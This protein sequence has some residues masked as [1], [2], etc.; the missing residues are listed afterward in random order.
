MPGTGCDVMVPPPFHAS[1]PIRH[2]GWV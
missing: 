2:L 1:G